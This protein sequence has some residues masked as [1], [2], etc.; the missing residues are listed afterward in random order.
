MADQVTILFALETLEYP[1]H[2]V[3]NEVQIPYGGE[4]G[5]NTAFAR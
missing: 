1:R 3:L 2:I 5:F 4:R